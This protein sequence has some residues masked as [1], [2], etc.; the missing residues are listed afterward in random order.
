MRPGPQR[1]L[2]GFAKR[3]VLLLLALA[4]LLLA[5]SGAGVAAGALIALALIVHVSVFGVAA[6]LAAAPPTALRI[7]AFAGLAIA[8]MA[9]LWAARDTAFRFILVRAGD[10]TVSPGGA[11]LHLAAALV[12]A[13]AAAFVFLAVAGRASTLGDQR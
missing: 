8:A 3:L 2:R 7:A 4:A 5:T 9:G 1:V 11:L 13:G 12:V 6:G 10:V